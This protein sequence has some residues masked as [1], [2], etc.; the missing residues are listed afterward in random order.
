M[1]IG[2]WNLDGRWSADQRQLIEKESCDVWLLTEVPK[3][4]TLDGGDV[5]RSMEMTKDKAWAAVWSNGNSAPSPSPHPAAATVVRDGVLFCSC[6]LP[7]RSARRWWPAEDTGDVATMTVATLARL[8]RGL[9]AAP[10]VVVW[11]G[12]WNHALHGREVAGTNYGRG[13]IEKLRFELQLQVPTE[14]QPHA[15]PGL[16]SIDHIAVPAG[17]QV[18]DRRRV[19][20]AVAG[21][22]LSDHDAYI[23]DCTPR[24]RR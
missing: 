14:R 10:G 8:R 17:W 5:F 12:D 22:R 11:G 20:A 23:V 2:T 19:V 15:K 24:T 6:V 21:K 1:K 3:K 9:L 7:W 18:T 13:E 16:L 4:F